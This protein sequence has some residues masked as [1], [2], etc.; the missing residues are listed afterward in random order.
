[1]NSKDPSE[2]LPIRPADPICSTGKPSEGRSIGPTSDPPRES[3]TTIPKILATIGLVLLL[4]AGGF[5]LTSFKPAPDAASLK[6]RAL[7]DYSRA[8]GRDTQEIL[9]VLRN[10][11]SYGLAS[12]QKEMESIRQKGHVLS[13]ASAAILVLS[14]FMIHAARISNSVQ[15]RGPAVK[16][17]AERLSELQNLLKQGLISSD[18]YAKRRSEIISAL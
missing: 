15:T 14:Y 17:S 1:M 4:V 11:T 18:E 3:G 10:G 8:G 2:D 16:S 6:S 7:A 12:F 9:E 13:V 5:Y